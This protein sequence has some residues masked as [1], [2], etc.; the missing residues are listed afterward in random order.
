MLI[1]KMQ[2]NRVRPATGAVAQLARAIA[3]QAIGC[4]FD[5][6]QLHQRQTCRLEITRRARWR[7]ADAVGVDES[8]KESALGR[9]RLISGRGCYP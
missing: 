4:G 3:L 9:N 8:G 6:R 1:E 5:P 2:K 7:A